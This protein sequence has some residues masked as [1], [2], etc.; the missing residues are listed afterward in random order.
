MNTLPVILPP[1]VEEPQIGLENL[2][3]LRSRR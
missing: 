3:L 2:F 1:P